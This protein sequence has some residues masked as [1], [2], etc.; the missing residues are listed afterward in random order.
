MRRDGTVLKINE[1]EEKG[2]TNL[3][4][5]ALQTRHSEEDTKKSMDF[6]R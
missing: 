3:P 2:D 5:V 4:L 1:G 6:P